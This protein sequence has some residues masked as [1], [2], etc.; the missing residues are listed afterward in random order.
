MSI[1]PTKMGTL[2]GTNISP[3]KR[4]TFEDDVRFPKV[5]YVIVPWRVAVWGGL[6][7]VGKTHHQLHGVE[8]LCASKKPY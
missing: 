8:V 3:S 7:L 4:G 1:Y 5:G 6:F 2:L